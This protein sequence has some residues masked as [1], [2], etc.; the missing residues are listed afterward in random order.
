MAASIT[1]AEPIV[2]VRVG[3]TLTPA[4]VKVIERAI[5]SELAAECAEILAAPLPGREEIE[6]IRMII[7]AYAEQ[8]ETLEWGDPRSDIE[9]DC[10]TSQLDTVALDLV[11]G[12]EDR[13][14]DHRV[15]VCATLEHLLA[16]LHGRLEN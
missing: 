12:G 11:D 6:R 13:R 10:P 2:G 1:S 3:V 7:D 15:A 14:Q 4:E 8:F 16:E 5:R 9:L